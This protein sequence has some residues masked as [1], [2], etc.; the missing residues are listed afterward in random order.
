MSKNK[1]LNLDKGIEPGKEPVLYEG[2][3]KSSVP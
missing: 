3:S 2:T 1:D